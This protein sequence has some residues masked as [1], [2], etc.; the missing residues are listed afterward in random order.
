[1]KLKAQS[2]LRLARA[3]E[4]ELCFRP[5]YGISQSAVQMSYTGDSCNSLTS[6]LIMGLLWRFILGKLILLHKRL[7]LLWKK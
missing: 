4:G 7:H 2:V 6:K 1:M 3:G 5:T